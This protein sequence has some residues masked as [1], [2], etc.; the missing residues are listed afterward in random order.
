MT[1]PLALIIEDDPG[2]STIF[3]KTLNNAG[4]DTEHDPDGDRYQSVLS[5]RKPSLVILDLHLPYDSGENILHDLRERYPAES[6][7]VIIVTADLYMAKALTS[8]GETVLIK[9]VSPAR[10]IDTVSQIMENKE[11]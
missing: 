2:L 11:G 5:S 4:Y 6:L 10:L 1:R 8:K 9:P 3:S 7:P